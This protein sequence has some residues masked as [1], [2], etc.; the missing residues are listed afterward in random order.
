MTLTWPSAKKSLTAFIFQA[1]GET[2]TSLTV[3]ESD[4]EITATAIRER[5]LEEKDML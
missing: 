2:K 1:V 3:A 5:K 4:A